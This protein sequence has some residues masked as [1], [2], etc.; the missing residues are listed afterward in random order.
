[1][2]N[3]QP[4]LHTE[5]L[6]LRPFVPGDAPR[7]Q[8]LAN[9]VRIADVTASIAHPYTEEMAQL[10]IAAHPAMWRNK[11]TVSFAITLIESNQLIGCISIMHIKNN[12]G[13]LGY[14]VGVDFWNNGYCTEACREV[15]N[16]G[17][18]Q[19]SLQRIYAHHLCRNP[20]SGKV[21]I[22]A[23]FKH[24]GSGKTPCGYRKETEDIE[25]YEIL[26]AAAG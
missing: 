12:E 24:T 19:L 9:D 16:F 23:G 11:E 4:T 18:K 13:E 6:K 8:V 26:N 2:D 5:R 20:A 21:L 25:I 10:W 14:W 7:V 22:K 3:Q 1:M 17:F 15:V